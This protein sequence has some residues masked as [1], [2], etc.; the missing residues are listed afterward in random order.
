[1]TDADSAA[2]LAPSFDAE[3][4]VG[5]Y[6]ER[7]PR[8]LA[9]DIVTPYALFQE[10]I[11]KQLALFAERCP[12]VVVTAEVMREMAR[13]AKEESQHTFQQIKRARY[14]GQSEELPE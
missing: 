2:A 4:L 7:M 5:S 12:G 13:E 10:S 9:A 1:M 8:A 6:V 14:A 3:A 11:K